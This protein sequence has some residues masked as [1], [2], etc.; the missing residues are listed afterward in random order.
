MAV[1]PRIVVIGEVGLSGELRAVPQLERR[2]KEVARLGFKR[3]LIPKTGPRFPA[4]EGI[5][6][7]T[8]GT[9]KEAVDIGLVKY[10]A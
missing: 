6:L 5:E 1:D 2:V 4:P 10:T 8:A 7:I 9:L 3:C